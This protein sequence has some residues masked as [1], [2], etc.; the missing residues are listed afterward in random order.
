MKLDSTIKLCVLLRFSAC[1]LVGVATA[2]VDNETAGQ[3]L[4]ATGTGGGI[5]V[6]LGC[7]DGKLTAAM[8]VDDRYTV[9]GLEAKAVPFT[10][11]LGKTIY[12]ASVQV[13]RGDKP[14]I[15]LQPTSHFRV[16]SYIASPH[17]VYFGVTVRHPN[18]EFAGRFQTTRPAV[19][20]SSGQDFEVILPLRDF[21]LDPSLDEM[22]DKLP[23]VPFDLVVESMWC[24]T[25]DKQAGLEVTKVE[26]IPP[27]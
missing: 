10:T 14:P 15:T 21:R 2:N 9:H 22:K 5:V 20:F 17:E 11:R 12:T 7:G 23:S 4:K 13:S 16:R 1:L 24:H 25:L 27:E 6:H 18:G 3:I 26:L 8:R 19:E